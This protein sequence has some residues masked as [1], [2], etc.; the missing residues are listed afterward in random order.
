M[1]NKMETVS[2]SENGLKKSVVMMSN[3]RE[4][5]SKNPAQWYNQG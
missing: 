5:R 3:C 1:G 2:S 4:T